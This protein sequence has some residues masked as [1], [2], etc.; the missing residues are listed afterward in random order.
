MQNG[1]A[2]WFADNSERRIGLW[3][4][5]QGVVLQLRERRVGLEG[6]AERNGT[7]VSDLVGPQAAEREKTKNELVSPGAGE[8]N[9][10]RRIGLRRG[11]QDKREFK[12]DRGDRGGAE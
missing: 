9:T 5:H 11:I 3:R 8:D 6:L 4:G 12:H 7:G 2:V 10:K 1:M